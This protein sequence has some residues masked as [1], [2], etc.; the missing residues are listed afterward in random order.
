M[1][2]TALALGMVSVLAI[3][4]GIANAA[5]ARTYLTAFK[6]PFIENGEFLCNRYSSYTHSPPDVY[7]YPCFYTATGI[8]G[9]DP[10]PGWWFKYRYSID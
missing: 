7:A 3:P 9:Y 4:G 5:S 2:L 1:R 10:R 6:G 8:P